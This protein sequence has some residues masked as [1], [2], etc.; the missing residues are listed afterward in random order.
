MNGKPVKWRRYTKEEREF[1]VEIVP[2]RSYS[3]IA[4]KF[5]ARF[6]P[7]ITTGQVK[8]FVGNNKLSTGKTGRFYKGQ[9]AHNKGKYSR[10][11]P[12]TEFAK[13]HVPRTYRPVGST[14]ISKDG[15]TEVKVADPSKWRLLHIVVYEKEYGKIPKGHVVVFADG[16]KQNVTRE[17]LMLATRAELLMLNRHKLVGKTKELT[18][19][20]LLAADLLMKICERRKKRKSRKEMN[21]EQHFKEGS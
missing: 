2:G 9:P 18:E 17:N 3:E 11:S 14:R 15:Y 19:T 8:S 1:L 7:P 16:N 6:S 5:N 21:Y 10:C 13:G 12:A 4:E 20:G